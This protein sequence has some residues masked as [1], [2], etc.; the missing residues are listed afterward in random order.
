[1]T[2]KLPQSMLSDLQPVNLAGADLASAATLNLDALAYD[3]VTVTG[4]VTVTAITLAAGAQATLR[5]T[6]ALTLTHNGTTLIL[7]GGANIVTTAGDVATFRGISGG[8]V[9]TGYTRANGGP[10]RQYDSGNQTVSAAGSL[11]LTHGLGLMPR[12]V[13]F[14]LKCTTAEFNY[15]IGDELLVAPGQNGT[16]TG[17]SAVIT[18]TA[19]NVRFGSDA[20]PMRILNKTTGASQSATNSSWALVVRASA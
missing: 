2:T 20:N 12:D 19:V 17:F 7:P 4:T 16:N 3:Y 11:A 8:V 10:L 6:G 15:S 1:M 14:V 9:C 13:L 5:F 18:T